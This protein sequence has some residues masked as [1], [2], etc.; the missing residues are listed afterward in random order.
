MDLMEHKYTEI[1]GEKMP[2]LICCKCGYKTFTEFAIKN[3]KGRLV[4]PQCREPCEDSLKPIK[5]FKFKSNE[6]NKHG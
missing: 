2:D 4:C 5:G 1:C 6:E 3:E